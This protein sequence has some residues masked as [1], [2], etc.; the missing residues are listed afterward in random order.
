MLVSRCK[1]FNSNTPRQD[2]GIDL[3][4]YTF[5][6][7]DCIFCQVA[8][9]STES[10]KVYE[11]EHVFAFLDINPV[12]E[13]HTLVISKKH[14]RDIFDV[15]EEELKEIMAVIKK[16]TTLYNQKLGIENVQIINSSGSE[17]QQDVFHVH[18]HI[19]P[20]HRGDGQD[21][22]WKT[23]PEWRAGF[24]KLLERLG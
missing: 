8:R 5:G 9:G 3:T 15:P 1:P 4:G 11:N 14:Y 16:L 7:E 6:M 21:V 10:W 13:Y 22:R 19:V 18:F 12:S 2:A 17:A 23:H 20:R 24:N